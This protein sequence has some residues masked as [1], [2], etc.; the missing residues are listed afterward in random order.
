MQFKGKWIII[1]VLTLTWGSSFIL[2]KKSLESFTPLQIGSIRV[3]ICGLIFMGIGIPAIKKMD[4]KTLG[5]AILTG[6]I[7]NFIPMF[8]FPIA[9]TRVSSSMAGIL[10][11][12]VPIFVLILGTLF[13]KIRGTLLQWAGAFIGFIGA[14]ML[15][16]FSSGYFGE[17]DPL[18]SLLIVL[19]TIC[20]AGS[21][22]LVSHR[23]AHVSSFELSAS[24]FTL[25]LIPSLI[26]FLF[27][28]FISDFHGTTDQ[29]KGLG[30]LS[31][32]SLCGSA[33]AVVLYFRL[34]QTTS[35]VFASMVTYLM[36]V[37]A[38]FWG[39]LSGEHFSFWYIVAGVLILL[40]IYLVQIKSSQKKKA[41]PSRR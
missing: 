18:F 8:L 11:S 24:V 38:V 3:S 25:W 37:V 36:P 16:Y 20:Y 10:D 31:V 14:A 26:V 19:A 35:A 2:I 33:M 32:L 28:G 6:S 34:I 41:L 27:S 5:Y 17:S 4:R 1:T 39:L 30:Y 29:W 21:A 40:G 22:S 9:Q 12:L 13:F 23:L 7:G 15:V